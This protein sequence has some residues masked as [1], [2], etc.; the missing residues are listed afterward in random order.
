MLCCFW[1]SSSFWNRFFPIILWNLFMASHLSYHWHP[2]KIA[3]CLGDNM[4][5]CYTVLF[6]FYFR[7]GLS[8]LVNFCFW[9]RSPDS[10]SKGTVFRSFTNCT[11]ASC[12]YF[13]GTGPWWVERDSLSPVEGE[14]PHVAFMQEDLLCPFALPVL[15][16]FPSSCKRGETL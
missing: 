10:C 8:S 16:F 5:G 11:Q 6:F 4:G 3:A 13:T 1:I 7:I 2:E 15:T 12:W 14:L 9:N